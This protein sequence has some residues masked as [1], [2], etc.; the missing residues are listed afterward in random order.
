MIKNPHFRLYFYK[1]NLRIYVAEIEKK[2]D[3]IL[4]LIFLSKKTLIAK[5]RL[6]GPFTY[7]GSF[8]VN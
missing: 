4:L 2:I 5:L 7:L 3:R 8:R 1:R 6:K